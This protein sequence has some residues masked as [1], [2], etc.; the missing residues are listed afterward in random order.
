VTIGRLRGGAQEELPGWAQDLARCVIVAKRSPM[1]G[2]RFSLPTVR[3]ASH[4]SASRLSIEKQDPLEELGTKYL[5][6]KRIHI[7][8]P[9]LT[10]LR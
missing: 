6:M 3:E 5:S 9:Y 10:A 4:P 1:S 7:H 2:A 8:L